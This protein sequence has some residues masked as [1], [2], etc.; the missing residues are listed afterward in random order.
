MGKMKGFD[1]SHFQAF[2][3]SVSK[4]QYVELNKA[5]LI[6]FLFD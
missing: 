2:E 4:V 1:S 5:F 6:L 3:I